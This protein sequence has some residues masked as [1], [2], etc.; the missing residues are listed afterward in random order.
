MSDDRWYTHRRFT[1]NAYDCSGQT[2]Q[3]I[4]RVHAE[5]GLDKLFELL[6]HEFAG[7]ESSRTRRGLVLA[8]RSN[9]R[10]RFLG[11]IHCILGRR[12]NRVFEACGFQGDFLPLKKV[13]DHSLSFVV[14]M[15][16]GDEFLHA[17]LGDL[18]GAV[19]RFAERITQFTDGKTFIAFA[20]FPARIF[21]A[22]PI[23]KG[24]LNAEEILLSL[25]LFI[26]L[27]GGIYRL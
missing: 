22:S 13:L 21:R 1:Q 4:Q 3:L 7:R 26:L 25:L 6:P 18:E 14:D 15:L 17:E 19:V 23:L 20:G 27:D 8:N 9:E 11:L 2:A 24:I 16:E 10:R 12:L 5:Q